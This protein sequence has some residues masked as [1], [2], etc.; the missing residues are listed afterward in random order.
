MCIFSFSICSSTS[1]LIFVCFSYTCVI[2]QNKIY[3][4]PLPLFKR[5]FTSSTASSRMAHVFADTLPVFSR[6]LIALL[7]SGVGS[8]KASQFSVIIGS[9][10]HRPRVDQW[11]QSDY[12]LPHPPVLPHPDWRARTNTPCDASGG[13]CNEALNSKQNRNILL[14]SMY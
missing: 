8:S 6:G 7:W 3:I 11:H 10:C 1:R 12:P 5:C 9:K 4:Y 2:F 14:P 13:M